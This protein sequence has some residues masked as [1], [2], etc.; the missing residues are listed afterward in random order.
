MALATADRPSFYLRLRLWLLA[1]RDAGL[2]SPLLERLPAA[3]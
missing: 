1:L 2:A 3:E